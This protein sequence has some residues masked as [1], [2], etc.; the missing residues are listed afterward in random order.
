MSIQK[1]LVTAARRS[2]SARRKMEHTRQSCALG[3]AQLRFYT[4]KKGMT[5][6]AGS[7]PL[8][9][10]TGQRQSNSYPTCADMVSENCSMLGPRFIHLSD[11]RRS[12]KAA[13][14]FIKMKS[15]SM[16]SFTFGCRTCLIAKASTNRRT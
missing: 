14:F 7:R 5:C 8:P 2:T 11:G 9:P 6:Y 13:I 3:D 16:R 10:P 15:R 4:D 12:A 1:Y